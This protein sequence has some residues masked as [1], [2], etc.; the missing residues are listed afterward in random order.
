MRK[1]IKEDKN[2]FGVEIKIQ[3]PKYNYIYFTKKVL[4]SYIKDG[5]KR[6]LEYHMKEVWK[7]DTDI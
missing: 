5:Y 6:V 4:N 1:R 7:K 3:C 2:E